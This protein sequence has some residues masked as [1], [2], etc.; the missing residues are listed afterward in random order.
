MS[1]IQKVG[2]EFCIKNTKVCLRHASFRQFCYTIGCKLLQVNG[3]S[4]NAHLSQKAKDFF[5]TVNHA[6]PLW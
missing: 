5:K 2:S 3:M 1:N 4:L 6:K